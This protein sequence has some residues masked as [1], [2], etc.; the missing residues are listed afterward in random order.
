MPRIAIVKTSSLGDVIHALP[1]VSDLL[2]HRPGSRIEWV[3]EE[4]FAELPAL[5]PGV[6]AVHR[7]ALRRWRRTPLAAPVRAEFAAFRAAFAQAPFDLILDL[8]GLLKSALLARMGRGPV[9]GADRRDAREPMAA[10]LYHQRHPV[11]QRQHAIAALRGLAGR[12]IGYVPQGPPRFD[13]RVPDLPASLAGP[14]SGVALASAADPVAVLLTM[15]ARADKLWPTA[16]WRIVAHRLE[17]A[18]VRVVLPWGSPAEQA[19]A[20]AIA[21]G[22][23]RAVVPPRLTLTQCAALLARATLVAGLDTG[24]TH[25]AAAYARPLVFIVPDTARWPRWRSE[26]TWLPGTIALGERGRLP[27]ADEVAAAC[28]RLLS[29]PAGAGTPGRA[30]GD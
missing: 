10:M 8:Q 25:L 28:D 13:L 26:P 6:A 22:L 17:A 21:H 30:A 18:G 27:A 19:R 16:D 11:D 9:A 1:V 29:A 12:A 3:V 20:Q 23:T 2:E 7:V 5:H 24:L 4:A 14:E 15:S